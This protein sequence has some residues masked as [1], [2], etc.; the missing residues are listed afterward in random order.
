MVQWQSV[1]ISVFGLIAFCL[2]LRGIYE[3][4][5]KH[6]SFG[7]TPWLLPYGIFVWGDAIIL[8]TFWF[9]VSSF[10]FFIHNWYLFLLFLSAFWLIRSLGETIYWLQEQFANKHRNPP[11]TL[12]GYKLFKNDS[13]WFIYQTFYQCLTVITLISTIYLSIIIFK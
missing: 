11:N 1:F 3:V 8:G 10:C 4:N 6:N 5:Q 7:L 12:F 9:L 2:T 13:V